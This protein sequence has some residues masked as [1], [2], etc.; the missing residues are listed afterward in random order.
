MGIWF[1][2]AVVLFTF[3]YHTYA[4]A[5]PDKFRNIDQSLYLPPF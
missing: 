5:R 4:L 3:I 1:L 2:L